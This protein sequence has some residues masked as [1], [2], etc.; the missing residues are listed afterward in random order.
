MSKTVNVLLTKNVSATVNDTSLDFTLD[1]ASSVVSVRTI[2]GT[3]LP[4]EEDGN[5]VHVN[6]VAG[7]GFDGNLVVEYYES[8]LS[9]ENAIGIANDRPS[10]SF[11]VNNRLYIVDGRSYNYINNDTLYSATANAYV[12]TTWINITVG[13]NGD[14]GTEYEQR[15]ML[16]PKFKNTFIPD[17][18]T[19]EYDL[20]ER[21][22]DSDDIEVY[23]YGVK[24]SKG[25]D[26]E[27]DKTMGRV[28]FPKGKIPPISTRLAEKLRQGFTEGEPPLYNNK[29]DEADIGNADTYP[30]YH[31]GVEITASKTYKSLNGVEEKNSLADAINNCTIATVFDNRVF[32]SGN[33]SYPNHI[34]YCG[35][36]NGY[37]D[38]TYFGVLNYIQDG[39]GNSPITGMIPVSNTLMVLKSDNDQD[40]TTFFHT[41]TDT[42]NH[43]LPR[44]YP[45]TQG[46]G[47]LGCIGA[48]VNFLD[49]PVF[50][51][52]LGLEGVNQLSVRLERNI[53][54][55][56]SLVDAYLLREDLSKASIAEWNGYLVLLVGGK[57]FLADS[58]Q[59]YT[60]D[61][62]NMQYE[63]YYLEDIAVYIGQKLDY[64]Y[65]TPTISAKI[66]HNGKEYD[67]VGGEG[68]VDGDVSVYVKDGW[69]ITYVIKGD[70]A[71]YCE[72][73][74]N[75][76]GGD[77]KE[78]VLVK[79]MKDN[80]FFGTSNGVVCS[81]NFDM[82]EKDGHIP[83]ECYTFDGRTIL[84]GFAT[85]M[86]NCGIPHLCK[87][88]VKK[89]LVIKTKSFISSAAK[90]KVRTNRQ[91]YTQVARINS[92]IFIF[93]SIDF[94][95]LSFIMD[96][97][98][99]FAVNEK[100]KKWVEKQLFFYSDEF[101]KPF[102]LYYVAQR[103]QVT[104]RYKE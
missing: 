44:I 85:L 77:R 75:M 49:D 69:Y 91:P 55:R 47:G 79:S 83:T 104:G 40:G 20:S 87:K 37:T 23:V 99:L 98:S 30:E 50:V 24:K 93:D 11:V 22:L 97:K 39:V 68:S 60:D 34:F 21:D 58:R 3:I 2:D 16:S 9:E 78:A 4:F 80:L 61:T 100:E 28:T 65:A 101:K 70:K 66:T 13:E 19:A 32:L 27:V 6:N 7:Q 82:R 90:I 48:C 10:T 54:H 56:S 72:T 35:M 88:T 81:F 42:G 96:E 43:V 33:K 95:D 38:P 12:P 46:L 67:L 26:Y 5:K 92:S 73:K 8:E 52:K 45:S 25:D 62:G 36:S 64:Q 14:A 102:G 71:V 103:Y 17:G 63:W 74:G 86:D 31:A 57:I 84:S 51:S 15:N 41:P 89:S 29:S 53:S 94:T 59:R 18:L 1:G 76:T